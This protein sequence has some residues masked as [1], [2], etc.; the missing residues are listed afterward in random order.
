[1]RRDERH[2]G[3][4]DIF[5]GIDLVTRQHHVVVLDAEGLRFTTFKV[6]HSKAGLTELVQRY[7]RW[8]CAKAK[9][10]ARR[11]TFRS[12][13]GSYR[14]EEALMLI[15]VSARRSLN[16]CSIMCRTSIRRAGRLDLRRQHS[17]RAAG[18]RNTPDPI[19]L[20]TTIAV[21]V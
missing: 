4:N 7:R 6:P 20:P 19:M 2:P 17:G 9:I 12:G 13:A 10:L 3:S 14:N 16:P 8:R 1:M 11:A 18:S 21:A 5:V 15:T